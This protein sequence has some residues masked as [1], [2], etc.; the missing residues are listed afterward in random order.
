MSL[1]K[2]SQNTGQ[3]EKPCEVCEVS[4][5]IQWKC[6]DCKR[7]MCSAC[8]ET[9]HPK[10]K[11]ADKHKI[12]K[13]KDITS[14]D[15]EEKPDLTSISCTVHDGK[16]C[17]LYCKD[18]EEAICSLCVTETHNK[19]TMTELSDGYDTCI[20]TL[21]RFTTTI[22]KINK[23]IECITL[24][25]KIRYE[26]GKR[27]MLMQ[28]KELIKA[29]QSKTK[30]LSREFERQW[31]KFKDI[32]SERKAACVE[33][34]T[35]GS[36]LKSAVNAADANET[37]RVAK[38]ANYIFSAEEMTRIST[39]IERPHSFVPRLI[40]TTSIELIHGWLKM[41]HKK[42]V[43][44]A[45]EI[46][47][48]KISTA[49][50]ERR[51]Y[52]IYISNGESSPT[53]VNTGM[54]EVWL[55]DENRVRLDACVLLQPN[56]LV[57]SIGYRALCNY[58]ENAENLTDWYLFENLGETLDREKNG[59]SNDTL[60]AESRS[61]TGCKVKKMKALDVFAALIS[62]IKGNIILQKIKEKNISIEDMYWVITIP[63]I[64]AEQF[65]R[66][67]VTMADISNEDMTIIREAD[68]LSELCVIK[69]PSLKGMVPQTETYQQC[70]MFD[71]GDGKTDIT[72][73]DI[74]GP[75]FV[76]E[77]YRGDT[78]KGNA[79]VCEEIFSILNQMLGLD[80][81][82]LLKEELEYFDF[83]YNMEF[84]IKNFKS[85]STEKIT[86]K[87]PC[88]SLKER[89]TE[90]LQEIVRH[91]RF[92]KH[93]SFVGDKFRFTAPFFRSLC[94]SAINYAS[95]ILD[96]CISAITE[97]YIS[98]RRTLFVFGDCSKSPIF[99]DVVKEKF[100]PLIEVSVPNVSIPVL[101]GALFC[102]FQ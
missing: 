100:G 1:S 4:Y 74:T 36:R 29:I 52:E 11:H 5:Q 40:S 39:A 84:K 23:R 89:L 46:G 87:F 47:T 90:P 48:N 13:T 21:K 99:M 15:L 63:N 50:L 38:R 54:M 75:R 9:I 17:C 69:E 72:L 64:T 10:F 76:K 85:E 102:G 18:C 31:D 53:D 70:L 88:C 8:K 92:N 82:S 67:A 20:E 3:V 43:V 66:D 27:K 71:L 26:D 81:V 91:S 51:S 12:I 62:Y 37:F 32:I 96:Q 35:K 14:E 33:I 83:I 86:F 60:L 101:T 28:E 68:A 6:F 98:E 58:N 73:M 79:L 45:I 59:F 24:V 42:P 97:E 65:I 78:W 16:L 95:G 93:V 25:E 94:E 34:E 49:Y 41:G 19:H 56:R 61:Y 55:N 7:Y 2:S 80:V 44:V 57:H 30:I 77:I 22:N